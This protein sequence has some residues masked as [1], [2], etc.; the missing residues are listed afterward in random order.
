MLDIITYIISSLKIL[1]QLTTKKTKRNT[2]Y[3]CKEI[4]RNKD[5]LLQISNDV[6][7]KYSFGD[8]IS[9]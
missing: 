5:I 2:L 8:E 6:R 3:H 9:L 1:I 7:T 4:L